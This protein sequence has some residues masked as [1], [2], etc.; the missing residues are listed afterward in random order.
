MDI[1]D[2]FVANDGETNYLYRNDGSGH[3]TEIAF[4]AGVAV[5][6][7]GAEQANMGVALGDYLHTGRSSLFDIPFQ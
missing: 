7:D 1:S 4:S 3:F 2:L 5:N 6:Q